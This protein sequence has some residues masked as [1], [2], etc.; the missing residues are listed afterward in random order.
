MLKTGLIHFAAHP[1]EDAVAFLT[2]RLLG[3]H[4]P[5]WR[6]I[7]AA[8]KRPRD[9]AEERRLIEEINRQTDSPELQPHD[10]EDIDKLDYATI[11]RMVHPKKGR[12]LPFSEDQIERMVQHEKQKS[13]VVTSETSELPRS[14]SEPNVHSR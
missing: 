11:L 10:E 1:P 14:R 9:P 12:W 6:E 8:P 2:T 13:A 5:R 4:L 7:E 3:K